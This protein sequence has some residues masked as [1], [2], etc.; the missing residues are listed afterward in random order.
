LPNDVANTFY[1][2]RSTVFHHSSL[3]SPA[4]RLLRAANP[5]TPHPKA[6][7]LHPGDST[8]KLD[9]QSRPLRPLESRGG[10]QWSSTLYPQF[11]TIKSL[12]FTPHPPSS[13]LNLEPSTLNPQP[14]ILN[15]Q[16]STLNP[17]LYTL[18]HAS[19]ATHPTSYTLHPAH[20]NLRL[21]IHQ[22]LT[23]SSIID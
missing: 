14:S 21:E 5:S 8:S 11:S 15:P 7:T 3:P 22:P 1:E 6:H 18:H 13:T 10:T 4:Q 9:Q 20:C 16:P 2:I 19:Y 12:P 17:T 23:L